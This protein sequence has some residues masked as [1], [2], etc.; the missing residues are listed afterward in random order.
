MLQAG[1]SRQIITPVKGVALA[2][3][4]NP[5]PNTGVL[6]DIY[7]RVVLFR[8]GK[9]VAG[10]VSFDL[11]RTT[12]ELVASIS[13]RL[14]ARGYDF[15][16]NLIISA[17]HTHTGPGLHRDQGGWNEAQ[18]AVLADKTVGAIE[19]AYANLAEV[20]L[21]AAKTHNNPCAFNR[22]YRMKNGSVQTNP[23]QLNPNIVRP[24]GPVDD[25]FSILA[26]R[27][28]GRIIGLISNVCNHNDTVGGTLVSA[29]W[30]GRMERFIQNRMQRD[31]PVLPLV[32]CSGNINQVDVSG[33]RK[34]L[35]YEEACRIGNTYGEIACGLLEKVEPVA[36]DKI[37]VDAADF[38]ITYQL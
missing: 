18:L 26:I 22:R 10:L 17:T 37:I 4:F 3:Y 23:G 16:D 9:T 27:Q 32:G 13:S 30:P 7:V 6:D 14:Q 38:E 1:I 15:A 21:E 35:C 19:E 31:I 11:L 8:S 25:E 28:E 29:E 24:E 34:H 5:R 33:N 36:V 12:L 2:G 20:T